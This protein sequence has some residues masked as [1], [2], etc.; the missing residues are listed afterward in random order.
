MHIAR[1]S[2][3]TTNR[4]TFVLQIEKSGGQFGIDIN[5]KTSKMMTL[6]YVLL[7]E[8]HERQLNIIYL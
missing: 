4:T 6:V 7:Y 1:S 2:G 3:V 5:Q 8:L